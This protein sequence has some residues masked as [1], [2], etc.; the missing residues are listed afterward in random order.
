MP[1][2]P[3]VAR[4]AHACLLVLALSATASAVA[5]PL[6]DLRAEDLLSM[7]GE[8]KKTLNLNVNQQTL[9]NQVE[10]RSRTVLRERQSRRLALQERAKALLARPDAE[11]RELDRDAEAEAMAAIAENRQ[12]RSLWLDVNDALDDSQRRKVTGMLSDRL[13]RVVPDG[14]GGGRAQGGPTGE[15]GKRGGPGMG[16]GAGSGPGGPGGASLNIGG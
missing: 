6:T 11:L 3:I 14:E 4:L 5:V 8:A 7:A 1:S 12:L 15:R 13:M 10:A 16:R 9:W 2:Y